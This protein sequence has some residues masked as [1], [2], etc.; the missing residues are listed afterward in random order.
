MFLAKLLLACPGNWIIAYHCNVGFWFYLSIYSYI[1]SKTE[2]SSKYKSDVMMK[3]YI[4]SIFVHWIILMSIFVRW[5]SFQTMYKLEIVRWSTVHKSWGHNIYILHRRLMIVL[6]ANIVNGKW[7]G[8]NFHLPDTVL[9][10]SQ[11]QD[12]CLLHNLNIFSCV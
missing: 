6:Y 8:N 3:N 9:V 1:I 4:Y 5:N 11:K 10:E 12:S 7:E 2:S